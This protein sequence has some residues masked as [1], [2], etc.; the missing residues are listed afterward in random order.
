MVIHLRKENVIPAEL[1]RNNCTKRNKY[2]TSISK[3]ILFQTRPV[4]VVKIVAV[5]ENESALSDQSVWRVQ[6]R[7]DM[8][9]NNQE[10]S[11]VFNYFYY[12]YHS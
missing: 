9:T 10:F 8:K 12:M 3:H 2:I 7:C 6:H 1:Q 11:L 5:M 4:T